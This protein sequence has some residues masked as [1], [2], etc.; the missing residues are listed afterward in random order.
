MTITR[1]KVPQ[2][3]LDGFI[4]SAPDSRAETPSVPGLKTKRGNQRSQVSVV[5][6]DA[7]LA[8]LDV[9][10]ERRYMSRSALLTMLVNQFLSESQALR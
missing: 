10:A 4:A 7:V 1:P 2:K 9:E 8:R 5:L 6:P 3:Q